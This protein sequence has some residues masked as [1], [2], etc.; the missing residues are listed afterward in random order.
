MWQKSPPTFWKWKY[1]INLYIIRTEK[2][3][4]RR[5]GRTPKPSVSTTMVRTLKSNHHHSQEIDFFFFCKKVQRILFDTRK[6]KWS[7]LKYSIYIYIDIII[8]RILIIPLTCICPHPQ[9]IIITILN[10]LNYI[11]VKCKVDFVYGTERSNVLR[12]I[13]GFPKIN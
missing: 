9:S 3:Q 10:A 2:S 1:S 13:S 11:I 4:R 12:P 6:K 7:Y 5:G 8:L